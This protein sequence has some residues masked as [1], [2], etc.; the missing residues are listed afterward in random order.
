LEKK[1]KKKQ[2]WELVELPDG[3]Q[4]IGVKWVFQK[5]LNPDDSISKH[6]AILVAKGFLQRQG[7]DFS[8]VY[9][10][11][12]RLER[13][14][15]VAIACAKKWPLFQLDVKS[16]FLHG[17]LEEEVYIQQ[18]PGFVIE[19]TSS[20]QAKKGFVWIKAN[21]ESLEQKN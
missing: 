8:E 1:K 11:V 16:A 14:R 9:A 4:K 2:T 19:G 5:K 6:K 21:P 15:V 20:L 17:H 13:I 18:P 3:K 12:A 10:L 7:L